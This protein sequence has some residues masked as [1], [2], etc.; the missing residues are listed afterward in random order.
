MW[1]GVVPR[2]EHL[3]DWRDDGRLDSFSD[4]A[5][6]DLDRFSPP[7]SG[8]LDALRRLLSRSSRVRNFRLLPADAGVGGRDVNGVVG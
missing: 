7:N 3:S 5:F 1:V 8:V 2:G 6:D 4:S